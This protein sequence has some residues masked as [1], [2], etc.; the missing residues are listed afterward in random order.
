MWLLRANE[1]SPTYKCIIIL[2]LNAT[3]YFWQ[4]PSISKVWFTLVGRALTVWSSSFPCKFW[5]KFTNFVDIFKCGWVHFMDFRQ[6]VNSILGLIVCVTVS[7]SSWWLKLKKDPTLC[8]HEAPNQKVKQSTASVRLIP[9]P[10]NACWSQLE[11]CQGLWEWVGLKGLLND[12][13]GEWA[14]LST[15][16]HTRC[17]TLCQQTVECST[18]RLWGTRKTLL[19]FASITNPE[20]FYL[21]AIACVP[22]NREEMITEACWTEFAAMG[23]DLSANLVFDLVTTSNII[24]GERWV[25]HLHNQQYHR[26]SSLPQIEGVKLSPCPFTTNCTYTLIIINLHSMAAFER[27]AAQKEKKNCCL[28]SWWSGKEAAVVSSVAEEVEWF[29]ISSSFQ[30]TRENTGFSF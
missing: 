5:V 9:E 27:T 1:K 15:Y 12:R 3:L 25:C 7:V 19:T 21:S 22:F 20:V 24:E 30:Q 13:G 2:Y 8:R 16:N 18:T 26:F 4:P 14:R 10:I 23:L 29:D 6:V 11:I 28:C 17:V